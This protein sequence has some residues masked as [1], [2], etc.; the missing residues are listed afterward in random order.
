MPEMSDQEFW[1]LMEDI[2]RTH[3]HLRKLQNLFRSVTGKE[4]VPKI[5]EVKDDDIH[6]GIRKLAD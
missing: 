6:G 5:V 2:D 4:R 1:Q 3:S